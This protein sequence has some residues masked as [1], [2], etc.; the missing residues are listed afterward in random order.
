MSA[1][2]RRIAPA[3]ITPVA[4]FA[5]VA[6]LAAQQLIDRVLARVNGEVV[7]LSDVRAGLAMGLVVAR[8]DEMALATEQWV[9]RR[10]LLAEVERFPPPEPEPEAVDA[11]EARL[12]ASIGVRSAALGLDDRRIRQ[13]ARDTLRIRTYLDQRFGQVVQISDDEA[14]AFYA[15]NPG[16]FQ[17]NGVALP[18]E[19][20]A[21]EVRQQAARSRR[22]ASVDQ[23]IG[24]LRVRADVVVTPD[25]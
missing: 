21:A 13:S 16:A 15:A 22:Q 25:P 9:Q 4:A 19:D 20:V 10:L 6:T 8:A 23:W 18:F 17:R 2:L 3:L 5:V 14:R 12:R 11:E 1:S 7:T 24:D